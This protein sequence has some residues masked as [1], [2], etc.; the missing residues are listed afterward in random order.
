MKSTNLFTTL[1]SLLAMLLMVSCDANQDASQIGVNNSGEQILPREPLDEC[2]DCPIGC[3]CC[4]IE[5]V[6]NL[7]TLELC[8]LCEGDY[9]CGPYSAGTPCTTISG[10]GKDIMFTI[11]HRREVFCVQPGASFRIHNPGA[12]DITIR[13]TCRGDVV[14]PVFQTYTIMAGQT[15]FFYSNGS[16]ITE[17][18]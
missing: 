11:G 5:Q 16:C 3:C 14:P 4:L 6:T 15:R 13:F 7:G 10:I 9:I 18:C 17:E 2:E 12:F 1:V 8:G